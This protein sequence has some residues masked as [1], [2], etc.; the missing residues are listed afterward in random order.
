MYHW[1]RNSLTHIYS[2]TPWLSF[3]QE[4]IYFWKQRFQIKVSSLRPGIDDGPLCIFLR[5][6]GLQRCLSCSAL[7]G[8]MADYMV[9]DW[10]AI[11]LHGARSRHGD[12]NEPGAVLHPVVSSSPC[13]FVGRWRGCPAVC[14]SIGEHR[15][16][17]RT[18]II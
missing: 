13:R 14:F 15:I 8:G 11:F 3:L 7:I 10:S 12:V 4:N 16:T 9:G 18:D 17:S 6:D 1:N 2:P 5:E